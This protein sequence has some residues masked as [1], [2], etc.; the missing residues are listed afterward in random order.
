MSAVNFYSSNYPEYMWQKPHYNWGNKI[1]A[2][3]I[4]KKINPL[5]ARYTYE[6][7][8][9]SQMPFFMGVVPQSYWLYGNLDYSFNKHHRHY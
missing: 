2:S 1:I 8:D 9:Y 5:R 7:N 4:Y 3:D 6:P